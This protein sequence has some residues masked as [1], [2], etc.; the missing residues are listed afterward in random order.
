MKIEQAYKLQD[1]SWK[2][3]SDREEKLIKPLVLVFGN[4]FALEES[5]VYHDIKSLYPDGE[6]IMGSTAGEILES[7]L[8]TSSI[9]LTAIEFEKSRYEIS[10]ANIRDHNNDTY[11]T[12]KTLAFGLSKE[13][14]NHVFIVSEGS[15]VNGSALISGLTENG[16]SVGV[17]GGL[18]GDDERFGSTIV[19]YNEYAIQGEIVIIGFYGDDLEISCSQY[20]GWDTFGPK[21]TITKSAGNVLYEIDN[22]PALD[23]YKKYL[24]TQSLDLPRSAILYPLYVQPLD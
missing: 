2:F 13:N 17:S 10:R 11:E 6:I 19:G 3:I 4:R 22:H 14:L 15:F 23:L 5:G 12:P 7:E 24:G 1:Q 18:C 20:C 9:T 21:R 8:Y 16:I